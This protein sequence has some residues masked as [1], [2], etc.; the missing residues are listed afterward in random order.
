MKKVSLDLKKKT[1]L[2]WVRVSVQPPDTTKHFKK[3][4]G[5]RIL[6]EKRGE[7]LTR[8]QQ[9][10]PKFLSGEMHKKPATRMYPR[11]GQKPPF[12]DRWVCVRQRGVE[13]KHSN[14]CLEAGELKNRTLNRRGG[15]ATRGK[16]A[17]W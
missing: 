14:D 16:G 9:G 2:A 8:Q 5:H 3:K 10:G 15:I 7:K 1:R 17:A 12:R 11:K 4:E 6:V 13:Q